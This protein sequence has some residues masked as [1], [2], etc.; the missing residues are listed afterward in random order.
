M[1]ATASV[2]AAS[3]FKVEV[4][5]TPMTDIYLN[6]GGKYR[7]IHL[8]LESRNPAG[9]LKAR[10]AV[11]LID[12]LENRELIKP[13][14]VVIESTS[15][16]LGVALAY[17]CARKGYRFVAVV[18]PKITN[19]LAGN[20]ASMGAD[21]EIVAEPD[22]NGGYLLTRL[23]RVQ[24][25]CEGSADYLWT[26]QYGNPANP[27]AHYLSTA[28]EIYRQMGKK[29]DAIFVAVSTG[30]T[31][32]GVGRYFREMSPRTKV[33]GVD[34]R[35]SVIFGGPPGQRKLTGIGSSRKS[36][37]LTPDVFD[38]HMIVDD[39][40]SF[41]MCRRIASL[42]ISLGGSSGSVLA[43]CAQYLSEHPEIEHS[44]CICPDGGDNYQSTIFNDSWMLENDF[45][46]NRDVDL[47][48]DVQLS[49]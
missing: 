12:D 41:S 35:G 39:Q 37:F 19:E 47:V 40:Q 15:G 9:S 38:S 22:A 30:G 26:N 2:A 11:S 3:P 25:L 10:T 44:V 36:D 18:D 4:G 16:N 33:V 32:A 20:I 14:S 6:I 45:S 31:L 46:T 29:V 34:A 7:A 17:I 48:N 5:N 28:P 1:S 24:Q 49:I 43:A 23:R 27:R 42:G 21:I 8:K 13:S